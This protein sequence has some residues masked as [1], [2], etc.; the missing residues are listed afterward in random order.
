MNVVVLPAANEISS[1]AHADLI[2]TFNTFASTNGENPVKR[3]AT[4][5]AGVKRLTNLVVELRAKGVTEASAPTDFPVIAKPEDA[6]PVTHAAPKA[7]APAPKA[8]DVPA[9]KPAKP[10]KVKAPAKPAK[11]ASPP[12]ADKVTLAAVVKAKGLVPLAVRLRGL[13]NQKKPVLDND[14]IF[15]IVEKEYALPASKKNYVQGQRIYA[16]RLAEKQ[17]A[18]AAKVK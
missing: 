18:R 12:V 5:S 6:R 15:A 1:M 17:A 4:R 11:S 14:A 3:F 9:Q 8:K 7:K 16:V 10:A 2:T 13:I